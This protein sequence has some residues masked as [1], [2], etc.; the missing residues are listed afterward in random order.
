MKRIKVLSIAASLRI[1]GAEKVAADIGFRADPQKYSV[2]YVV[3]GDEI[4]AYEPELEAHGCK[5]FH[6]PSP[7]DSY[8]AYLS[9]LKGQFHP[10]RCSRLLPSVSMVPT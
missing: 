10:I 5:I 6:L 1:G 8:R 2:H 9:G 7:S 3:F 4:G